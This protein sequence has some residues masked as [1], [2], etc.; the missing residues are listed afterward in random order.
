MPLL[1]VSRPASAGLCA[2]ALMAVLSPAALAAPRQDGP[3]LLRFTYHQGKISKYQMTM[4]MK[5]NMEGLPGG[6]GAPAGLTKPMVTSS[7]VRSVVL[8]VLPD[9]SA[10][11]KSVVTAIQTPGQEGGMGGLIKIKTSD[12]ASKPIISVLDPRGAVKEVEGLPKDSK[13]GMVFSKMFGGATPFIFL[14][15]N[16]VSPG[17]TWQSPIDIPGLSTGGTVDSTLVRYDTVAGRRIA[18]ITY[19]MNMPLQIDPSMFGGT[20]AGTEGLTATGTLTGT[21]ALHLD[22][23]E[24]TLS[25]SDVDAKMSMS[26]AF[27]AGSPAAAQLPNGLKMGMGMRIKMRPLP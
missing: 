16:P 26:M 3:Q 11:V 21:G 5:V 22:L 25:S 1:N 27:A 7:R 17:D 20:G 2:F 19:T 14:P 10:R 13:F 8:Q 18:V 12:S 4:T 24:G 15:E 23:A 6:A 9:G